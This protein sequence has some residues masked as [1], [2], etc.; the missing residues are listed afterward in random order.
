MSWESAIILRKGEKIV[1]YWEGDYE[2]STT[3]MECGYGPKEVKSLKQG[4][5]IL[6][7]QRIVWVEK[8]GKSFHAIFKISLEDI[9]GI[10]MGGVITKYVSLTDA[11]GENIFHLSGIGD[12]ELGLFKKTVFEQV[13]ARK[14]YRGIKILAVLFGFSGLCWTYVGMYWW[15]KWDEIGTITPMIAIGIILGFSLG[16]LAVAVFLGFWDV[17]SWSWT[18]A[19]IF[20]TISIIVNLFILTSPIISNTIPVPIIKEFYLVI[21]INNT[22]ILTISNAIIFYYLTRPD[23]KEFFGKGPSSIAKWASS[24]SYEWITALLAFILGYFQYGSTI[25]GLSTVLIAICLF[26]L[27]FFGSVPFIGFILYFII[28][29]KWLIPNI[30]TFVGLT[31]SWVISL[32]LWLNFCLALAATIMTSWVTYKFKIS[33]KDILKGYGGWLQSILVTY[34]LFKIW[35]WKRKLKKGN[36]KEQ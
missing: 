35:P 32:F 16:F 24:L 17:K 13:E 18:L 20:Q 25:G 12:K 30:L 11:R 14:R 27:A 34:K 1:S 15:D 7:N 22:I 28:A 9:K 31:T 21:L 3:V 29:T 23:V 26:F 6:T 4:A 8:R 33:W 19:V 5:L 10:S 2:T 36:E